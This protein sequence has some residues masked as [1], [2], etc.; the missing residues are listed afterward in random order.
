VWS[1]SLAL[2][3]QQLLELVE[4]WV[5]SGQDADRPPVIAVAGAQGSGK[6]TLCRHLAARLNLAHFSL[7]DV[8]L[9]RAERAR[10]AQA[11]HPLFAVRGAP[12][13]HDLSLAT[14]VIDAL[15]RA[16]PDTRTAIPS[17]D[18]LADERRPV[19]EWPVFTGR[20]RAILIDGWCLGATPLA[21]EQ[22]VATVNALEAAEDPDGAWRRAWNADL[23]G[24][25][26]AWFD[27]FD[28]TLF[29]RAPSF[30]VVLDWRCE[31]EASA[32]GLAPDRLPKPRRAEL[33]TFIQAY[34]RLTRHMLCGGVRADAVAALDAERRV[35][36][37]RMREG[38]ITGRPGR[39]PPQP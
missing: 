5:D 22:L 20:P 1:K 33:A 30:D 35:L 34:E 12:G 38:E 39:P 19:T 31:Q 9:T 3:D 29:L 28:A 15:S 10:L 11:T 26:A 14:S 2:P 27:S 17:F 32:L 24:R 36:E 37:I 13:T 16:D 21:L 25:Y 23:A 7:D 18:K 6:T 4:R 8:Y